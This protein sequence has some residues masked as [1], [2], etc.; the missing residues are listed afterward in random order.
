MNSSFVIK[1]I[2]SEMLKYEAMKEL[3]PE[4]LKTRVD[5]A[6]EELK[7]IIMQLAQ[8]VYSENLSDNKKETEKKAKKVVVDFDN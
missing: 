5:C 6:Q 4:C 8:E 2:K 1:M 7:D 3:L